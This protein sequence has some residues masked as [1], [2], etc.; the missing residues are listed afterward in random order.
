MDSGGVDGDEGPFPRSPSGRVP[1]W[2]LD[3]AAGLTVQ[4]LPWRAPPPPVPPAPRRR[5]RGRAALRAFVVLL[6]VLLLSGGAAVLVGPGP[7]AWTA[8]TPDGSPDVALDAPPTVPAPPATPTPPPDRPT[9]GFEASRS[10]LGYPFEAPPEGGPHTFVAFQADGVTAVAYD[11]C[12]PIH[13]VLRPDGAPEGGE[14]VVRSAIARMSE[15]TGLQFIEDGATD[16]PTTIDRPI[17][18]PERYGDR[19]APVLIAWE[20]EEQNPALAGDT[21]GQAGSVAVSLGKGPRVFVTGTVS[22][23]AGR[24]P[25]ILGFRDGEETARAIVLHELGHLV[26][27]GHVDDDTQLMYPEARREVPDLADGDLTGLSVLGRGPCVAE[28]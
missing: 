7:W 1:Q 19:W 9:G 5:R 12:R 23:D 3:E 6:L 2:V 20:T 24:I 21:V 22:L 13:Y 8:P 17:Y 10:P 4:P 11:P 16:E 25:E 26:G 18:Q 28:L 14:D 27:L 15:V